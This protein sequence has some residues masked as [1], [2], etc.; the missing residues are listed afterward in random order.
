MLR[1]NLFQSVKVDAVYAQ[2]MD[3]EFP[4]FTLFEPVQQHPVK[5]QEKSMKN[6]DVMLQS[7][8]WKNW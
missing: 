4:W 8:S 3:T 1:V 5:L 2:Q 6:C 7:N